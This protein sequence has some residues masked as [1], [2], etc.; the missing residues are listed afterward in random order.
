MASDSPINRPLAGPLTRRLFFALW[1]SDDLR[2]ALVAHTSEAVQAFRCRPTF[3]NNLHVTLAFLG[4][5]PTARVNELME[6]GRS[7][8]VS[9]CELN[10]DRLVVWKQARVLALLVSKIPDSLDGFVL[11]LQA[12]LL[13]AGFHPDNK[14]YRVHVTLARDVRAGAREEEVA[15]LTWLV[16]DFVLVESLQSAGGAHYEVIARFA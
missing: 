14:P 8:S 7:L 10:F 1:P 13:D 15:T 16:S 9:G 3:A 2:A 12:R 11:E 6:I 4:A 5:V